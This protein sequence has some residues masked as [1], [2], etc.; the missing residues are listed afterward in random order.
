MSLAQARLTRKINERLSALPEYKRV[1]AD[2]AIKSILGRYYGEPESKVEPI[3]SVLLD[4]VEK[5]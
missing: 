4:A 2:K 5:N 1:Y 3:V